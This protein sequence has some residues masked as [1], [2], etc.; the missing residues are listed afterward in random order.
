MLYNIIAN[1]T[2]LSSAE[3]A[4][5]R[6]LQNVVALD[7]GANTLLNNDIVP[8][9]VIGDLDSIAS[10]TLKELE[11]CHVMIYNI[12]D[13]HTTDLEKGVALCDSLKASEIHIYNAFGERVDHSLFNLRI[14]KK[15]HS[16]QRTLRI[17]NK[18]ESAQYLRD[19]I[20][21][22]VGPKNASVA[23]MAFP[24]AVISSRGLL[25]DVENYALRFAVQESV[26]N[27][28]LNERAEII[29]L[30]EALLIFS[31]DIKIIRNECIL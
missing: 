12:P 18:F 24:D 7:G 20:V 1:A 2:A 3:L 4:Q 21:Q 15:H 29:I 26:S 31:N 16:A 13:Q 17:C 11:R 5:I 8:Q 22:I 19:R 6:N 10:S 23:L 14:L 30:R 27:S 25:Y 9:A 28:L